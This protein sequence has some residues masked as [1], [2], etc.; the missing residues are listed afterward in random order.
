MWL[1]NYVHWFKNMTVNQL[2]SGVLYFFR[3]P[4]HIGLIKRQRPNSAITGT[5]VW[6]EAIL[7]KCLAEGHKHHGRSPDSKT[8]GRSTTSISKDV[9]IEWP[10][11]MTN[12]LCLYPT[13]KDRERQLEKGAY[14]LGFR[15]HADD[16]MYSI[17]PLYFQ[18]RANFTSICLSSKKII[19]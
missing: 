15:G 7:V 2:T 9:R 8:W 3:S 4:M 5:P 14:L 11:K 12:L 18:G 1:C 17:R 16:A 13:E 10:R 19:T 6:R